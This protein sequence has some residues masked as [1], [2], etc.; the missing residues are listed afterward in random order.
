MIPC[1]QLNDFNDESICGEIN[2][3]IMQSQVILVNEGQFFGGLVDFVE[4]L[5]SKE[6]YLYLWTRRF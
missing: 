4:L 5:L 6:D 2:E 1:T 3:K